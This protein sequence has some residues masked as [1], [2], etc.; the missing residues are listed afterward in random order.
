MDTKS[1]ST[2]VIRRL[3]GWFSFFLGTSCLVLSLSFWVSTI[4]P[5]A[6]THRLAV[7]AYERTFYSSKIFQ[8]Y[9]SHTLYQIL[10]FSDDGVVVASGNDAAFTFWDGTAA[11]DADRMNMLYLAENRNTGDMRTNGIENSQ[12]LECLRSGE[13]P[14]DFNFYFLFQGGDFSAVLDGKDLDLQSKE[15]EGFLSYLQTDDALR[16]FPD[17][18][19]CEVRIALKRTDLLTTDNFVYGNSRDIS[20]SFY[21]AFYQYRLGRLVILCVSSATFAGILLFLLSL[22]HI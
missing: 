20:S 3:L 4:F 1:K 8:K 12:E 15:Y 7:D 5:A 6:E 14:E 11:L 9:L 22:I 17:L 13:L 18:E 10:R 16:N 2:D 21:Y 19:N